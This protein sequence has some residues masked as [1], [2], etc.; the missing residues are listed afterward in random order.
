MV[1]PSCA[2]RLAVVII[3]GSIASPALA[4]VDVCSGETLHTTDAG[5]QVSYVDT[6]PAEL[7][8]GDQRI[9]RKDL[10]DS[11]G[12][13]VGVFRWV[14]TVMQLGE[15]DDKPVYSVQK[16]YELEDGMLFGS[17][18]DNTKSPVGDTTMPSIVSGQTH[19]TGGVGRY[20]NVSGVKRHERHADT[21]DFTFYFEI[22]CQ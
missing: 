10:L 19:V 21:G 2:L 6:A 11:D 5:R 1:L 22:E 14:A 7:S 12:N 4:Q 17:S 18:I 9:G 8:I 20:A 3:A 15:G 16:F 13:K